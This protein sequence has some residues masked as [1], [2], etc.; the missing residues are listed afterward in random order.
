MGRDLIVNIPVNPRGTVNL[1]IDDFVG[2]TVDI[3][4]NAIRLKKTLNPSG[5]VWEVSK[6]LIHNDMDAWAKLTAE[7]E[8]T[9]QT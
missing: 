1:C 7:T 2:L 9:E 4:H 8:L 5:G 3:K 6:S